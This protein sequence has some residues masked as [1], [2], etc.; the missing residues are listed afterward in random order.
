MARALKLIE[1]VAVAAAPRDFG[2]PSGSPRDAGP[3]DDRE[4]AR[5]TRANVMVLG[6]QR[7]ASDLV[8]SL[9]H[10]FEG[11]VVVRHDGERLRL[12]P[13]P[14]PARTMVLHGVDT[15][16]HQEQVALNRWLDASGGRT[17]IVSTA[18]PSLLEMVEAQAFDAQLYYRLNVL[19]LDLRSA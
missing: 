15:L 16:T 14:E 4:L 3:I 5:R 2:L 9:W 11:P 12:S 17:R 10:K 13:S 19:C 6:S 1:R 7:V 8:V 18:P